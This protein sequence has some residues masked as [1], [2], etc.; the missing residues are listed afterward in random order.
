MTEVLAPKGVCYFA[1]NNDQLDYVKMA[2][3]AG[4]YVKKNLKLPVCLITDE[5]SESWL[6]ESHSKAIIKE[7]FDYIII[8]NDVMKK[9]R[10]RH[11]DSP[12][13]EF[14]AQ[15]NNSNKHKI[16]EY[17]PFEQTLLLDIDYIVKTDTLLK[18]FDNERP[19]CMF[20]NATTVRNET[21][22]LEERFL[23]DAGIKMWWSTVVYFDRSDFSKMFFDT[24]SHVAENYEFYQYLYNFPSK[25]FRTDYCVSIAVHILA[26]MQDT[27]VLLG[28]FD[29][30][31]LLNMSQKDDIIKVQNANEWIMLAHD[32]KEVWKNILVKVQ[33]Q[34]IHVMNKRAFDRV[35]PE[36][37]EALNAN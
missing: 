20:D 29:G 5:G 27:Q 15:F 13:T 35:L 3:A 18:Y 17:S 28:N 7:V 26:G 11:F 34:D 31:A 9:N 19:V 36:L 30:T 21:P 33:N 8:T 12:W 25:L 37:M 4:K 22:A 10:R 16:Y 14:A 24:W 2:L 1:Y 32:Q 6:E 23:Y